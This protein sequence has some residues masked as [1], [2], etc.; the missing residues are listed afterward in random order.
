M[1]LCSLLR[2]SHPLF[3]RSSC[4]QDSFF[5]GRSWGAWL[6]IGVPPPDHPPGSI[7]LTRWERTLYFLDTLHLI[8]HLLLALLLIF[9]DYAV[10]WVLDLARYHLQGEIVA[11]S[12]SPCLS[13]STPLGKCLRSR[14][15]S[16]HYLIWFPIWEGGWV[17][18]SSLRN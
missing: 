9:L 11:R 7:F 2:G 3:P 6:D 17:I 14:T 15:L 13:L 12:E 10:F 16:H 5:R 1:S 4:L 8:R 18:P